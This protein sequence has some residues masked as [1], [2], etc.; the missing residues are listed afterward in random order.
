MKSSSSVE[1]RCS[2]L[3]DSLWPHISLP[4]PS[5]TPGVY[6]NS[7]PFSRWC[8]PTI[9]SSVVPFPFCLQSFTASGFFPIS[10]FF[11]WGG[12][13]IGVSASA[14]DLPMNIQDWLPLGWTGVGLLGSV[15][16]LGRSSGEGDSYPLHILA[17]RIPRTEEPG[18]L[19][20]VHGV[21]KSWA[22]LSDFHFHISSYIPTN[23]Q[24][25]IW[26]WLTEI[27]KKFF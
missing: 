12:Q 11:T 9:S 16:G 1:F 18:R 15:P 2:V 22:T 7:S 26:L 20:I 3:S 5:S 21:T 25:I 4:C 24:V 23:V 8:H 10:Q 17:W 27:K 13:G 6:T 14:S 19:Y